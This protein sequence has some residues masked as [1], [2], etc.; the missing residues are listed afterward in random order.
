MAAVN[1]ETA[2]SSWS[3]AAGPVVHSEEQQEAS[4]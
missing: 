3:L 4:G 1:F 2:S